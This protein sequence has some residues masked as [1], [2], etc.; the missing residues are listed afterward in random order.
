[1]VWDDTRPEILIFLLQHIG[2]YSNV[3]DLIMRGRL[4]KF[5]SFGLSSHVLHEQW[6]EFALKADFFCDFNSYVAF[7]MHGDRPLP[8]RNITTS[9]TSPLF[10]TISRQ[11]V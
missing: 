2:S 5:T 3:I 9:E 8:L 7:F 6:N 10:Y 11:P 4:L 1:M